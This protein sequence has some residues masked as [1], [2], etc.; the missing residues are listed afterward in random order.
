MLGRL[1]KLK[2]VLVRAWMEDDWRQRYPGASGAA[3]RESLLGHLDALLVADFVQIPVDGALVEQARK[4]ASRLSPAQR[5]YTGLQRTTSDT[6]AWRPAVALGAAGQRLFILVSKGDLAEASVPGFFTPAGL[7]RSVLPAL[8]KAIANAA[9]EAWVFG[10]SDSDDAAKDPLRLEEEVL[11]LYAQGFIKAWDG[12]LDELNLRPLEGQQQA[13][14]A[15]SILGSPKSPL[16]D[17]MADVSRQLDL[18]AP[19]VVA[20]IAAQGASTAKGALG[21]A[22]VKAGTAVVS[23]VPG[24]PDAAARVA[25]VMGGQQRRADPLAAAIKTVEDHFRPLREAA[26]PTSLDRVVGALNALYEQL[27]RQLS[28]APGSASPPTAGVDPVR[29][30]MD[31]A[32]QAPA[33]LSRWLQVAAQST[34]GIRAG[35][36]RAAVAAAAGQQLAPFCKGVEA[37]FPFR[38]DPAAPDMP[39]DDFVRLFG[40]GGAFDQF[41]NQS[42]KA[43]V[44][45]SQRPWRPVPTEGGASPISAANLAQFQRAAAIRDAFFPGNQ[46]GQAASLRFELVLLSLDAGARGAT[47]ESDGTRI[48]IAAGAAGSRPI[49][50]SW[51]AR[52]VVSLAFDGEPASSALVSDGPWAALRLVAR[53]RLTP[54]VVPDRFRWS[55]QQGARTAEFELRTSSIVNPFAARELADFRCPQ[56]TP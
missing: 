56:L 51:P 40:P 37:R 39:M 16:R 6:P 55:V 36:A 12:L 34:A 27:S 49:A 29:R 50:L 19:P 43:F 5:I 1:G 44:D 32:K 41:F 21:A 48:A 15:L 38:R 17:L 46:A 18:S 28:S 11:R 31:E 53:G 10:K 35:D 7:H 20:S 47:L 23:G 33:P 2:P 42:L 45:T 9:A 14:T 22:A 30:L 3:T 26:T 54:G 25:E 8:P 13:A 24:M 52:G 4:V